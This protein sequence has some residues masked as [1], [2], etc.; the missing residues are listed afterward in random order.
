MYTVNITAGTVTLIN[1]DVTNG[2]GRPCNA[3]GYNIA[4]GY[5]YAILQNSS[6]ASIVRLSKNGH[7]SILKT[8][9]VVGSGN[10]WQSG[11]IDE[12]S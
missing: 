8:I 4:N 6:L 2:D 1:S 7:A 9:P 11:E 10:S 12:K 3:I 5:I